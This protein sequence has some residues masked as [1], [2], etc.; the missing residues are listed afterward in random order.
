MN[1]LII[2]LSSIGDILLTTPFIRQTRKKY[3]DA[4]IEYVIKTEFADLIRNN[5][6]INQ[7]YEYNKT[8]PG[9]PLEN[10][11]KQLSQKYYDYIFDLHN[12]I[13]SNYLRRKTPGQYKYHIKKNKIRQVALVYLKINLYQGG[14][15]IPERYLDVGIPAGITDDGGGLEIFWNED[16]EKQVSEVLSSDA[17]AVKKNAIALAPGAGY[18]TKR[19]PEEHFLQLIKMLENRYGFS[20]YILGGTDETALGERLSN[21]K[22]VYNLA[23]KLTLRQTAALL[24]KMRI[25]ISNDS[26]MMHMATAVNT[27]VIAI[28]GSSVE[29]LGFYP[30]RSES[31]VVENKELNCRPCS[32]VGRKQ[33][34]REHFK[35]MKDISADTVFAAVAKY[36]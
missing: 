28:F 35:C 11:A 26:G 22:N 8:E 7:F 32:H 4:N 24:A 12:N 30:Y 29:E 21:Q 6:H 23:G 15:P 13:R 1:I 25:L 5:P 36:V 2:R 3:P 31:I 19:W 18:F 34:P 17:Q 33:C 10:I 14:K 27:P 20:I 9:Q 16:T